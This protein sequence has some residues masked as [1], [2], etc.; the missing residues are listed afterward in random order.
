MQGYTVGLDVHSG[1]T[2]YAI[3][4]SGGELVARGRI[5]TTPQGLEQ[6]QR[7]AC[8]GSG[9][10]GGSGDGDGVVLRRPTAAG[11]GSGARGR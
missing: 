3:E 5:P 7:N 9:D 2:T 11:P 8:A 4:D 1:W 10:E 6:L